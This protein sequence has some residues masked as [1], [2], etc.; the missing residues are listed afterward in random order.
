M[1]QTTHLGTKTAIKRNLEEA[2]QRL[3]ELGYRRFRPSPSYQIKNGFVALNPKPRSLYPHVVL[4]FSRGSFLELRA[5]CIFYQSIV[6][7]L[8][9]TLWTPI[10]VGRHLTQTEPTDFVIHIDQSGYEDLEQMLI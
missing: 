8:R 4:L 7:V 9:K 10:H 3:G 2:T 6:P 5:D 1:K